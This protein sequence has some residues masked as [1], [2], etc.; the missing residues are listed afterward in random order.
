MII[1]DTVY[2]KWAYDYCPTG[3]NPQSE[4]KTEDSESEELFSADYYEYRFDQYP[5][6]ERLCWFIQ[7]GDDPDKDGI[8]NAADLFDTKEE[9]LDAMLDRAHGYI[10]HCEE[11]I[12]I[13]E[14]K[15]QRL[16]ESKSSEGF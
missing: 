16:M 4:Y 1:K 6:D 8:I 2:T 3:G 5:D 15:I 12:A 9:C 11:G 7:V 10:I 14:K 13:Y